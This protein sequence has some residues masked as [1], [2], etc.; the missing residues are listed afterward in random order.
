MKWIKE[1]FKSVSPTYI[2]LRGRELL[3][4][5]GYC[6]IEDYSD[7]K[8]V[9]SNAEFSF[10]VFGSGLRLRHLSEGIMAVDGRID[11]VEFI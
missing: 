5:E 6:R 7:E 11:R 3:L 10:S 1:I 9:L 8:I 2:E 4:A